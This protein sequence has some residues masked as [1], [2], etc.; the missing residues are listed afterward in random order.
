MEVSLKQME[1]PNCGAAFSLP[2]DGRLSFFCSYCGTQ[3]VLEKYP[4]L[5]DLLKIKDADTRQK[6]AAV[7]LKYADAEVINANTRQKYADATL[8]DAEARYQRNKNYNKRKGLF[9]LGLL[10]LSLIFF[11][12]AA[13]CGFFLYSM[14]Q[15]GTLSEDSKT[16]LIIGVVTCT[17]IGG[18]C[19]PAA[20]E[21]DPEEEE[22]IRRERFIAEAND[23]IASLQQQIERNQQIVLNSGTSLFGIEAEN[24]RLAKKE[25]N[26]LSKEVQTLRKE[27]RKLY[28]E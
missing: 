22:R 24:R 4:G 16:N 28:K 20:F 5:D 25:I 17:V 13:V 12:G 19:I 6:E 7:Q 1:C 14:Y 21:I 2:H 11:T 15:K 10:L 3:I 18:S 8:K 26:S 9:V 23:K 27:I